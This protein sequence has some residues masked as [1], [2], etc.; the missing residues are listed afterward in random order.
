[1]SLLL[2]VMLSSPALFGAPLEVLFGRMVD[3]G[4]FDC[5]DMN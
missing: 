4:Q 2:K 3:G 5:V 1:M